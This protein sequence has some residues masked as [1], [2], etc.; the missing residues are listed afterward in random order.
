[1]ELDWASPIEN[2]LAQLLH[3]DFMNLQIWCINLNY[4]NKI[5]I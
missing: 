4:I 5:F 2:E 3:L 1:M